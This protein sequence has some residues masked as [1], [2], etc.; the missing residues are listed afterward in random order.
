MQKFPDPCWLH[1]CSKFNFL[2]SGRNNCNIQR[3]KTE[4]KRFFPTP[5]DDI[6]VQNS[7]FYKNVVT[8]FF[9]KVHKFRLIHQKLNSNDFFR[10]LVVTHLF[11]IRFATKN[12]PAKFF[13]KM[14]NFP[15]SWQFNICSK[16]N[17]LF[18]GGNN[19]NIQTAKTEFEMF[20]NPWW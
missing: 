14:Q 2:S 12:F 7:I 4:F 16:F 18:S 17:F 6:F 15:D 19:F 11:Q 13:I 5:G 20:S 8:K 10:P 9:I 3:E 1:I